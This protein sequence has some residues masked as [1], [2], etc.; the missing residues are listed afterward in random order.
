MGSTTELTRATL[1]RVSGPKYPSLFLSDGVGDG[2]ITRGVAG[3]CDCEVAIV[4]ECVGR[5]GSQVWRRV[6]RE[7]KI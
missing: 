1:E 7:G 3:T 5:H 6:S 4:I 2:D